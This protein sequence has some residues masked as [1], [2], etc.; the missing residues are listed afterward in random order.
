MPIVLVVDPLTASRR[1]MRRLLAFQPAVSVRCRALPSR[2]SSL[3]SRH[4]SHAWRTRV[5]DGSW[6]RRSPVGSRCSP[7]WPAQAGHGTTADLGNVGAS[8]SESVRRRDGPQLSR[9]GSSRSDPGHFRDP[10]HEVDL[11]VGL[12]VPAHLR[13][14]LLDGRV[15]G[16]AKMVGDSAING[17][18]RRA[19]PRRR[20]T[21]TPCPPRGPTTAHPRVT[22]AQMRDRRQRGF[23]AECRA[24]GL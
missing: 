3:E 9:G 16:A 17:T 14:D 15:G 10:A 2:S 11:R 13:A 21:W 18:L 19:R 4:D 7:C 12:E 8:E 6:T 5:P 23:T 24:A 22:A 1:T 20:D